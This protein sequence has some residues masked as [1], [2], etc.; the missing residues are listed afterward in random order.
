MVAMANTSELQFATRAERLFAALNWSQ[1]EGREV[2]SPSHPSQDE[3]V[4]Q[5]WESWHDFQCVV[6][7]GEPGSGK[8][9]E[10]RR[11]V[12]ELQQ[13]GEP[14]FM[15]CWQDWCDGDDIFDTI[16]NRCGFFSAIESSQPVWWFV[17][18][19]DEGRIKTEAAFDFLRKGLRRLHRDGRLHLVKLRLSCRSRDWRLSEARQLSVFFDAGNQDGKSTESVATL[20]LLPLHEPSIRLL[21]T[22][23]LRE[24]R[25]V[26]RF[27]ESL[28]QR[29]VSALAGH[30]L[31]LAMMLSLYLEDNSSLAYDRTALYDRAMER[32]ATEHNRERA[33]RK[34]PQTLPGER[35]AVARQ[36]AVRTILG[37]NDT[38]GVPDSDVKSDRI[39]DASRTGAKRFE[40]LETL[41]TGLF[42]QHAEGG[43]VF[44]H[45][46]FA[47]YLAA[48]YLSERIG[49][50]PLSRII[51]LFPVE[52]G[53]IPGPLRE[54][55]SWLAGL[56]DAFRRWLIDRDPLTAA[57]G[58]TIRYTSEERETLLMSLA[59]RFV[60][61]KW[62]REFDRFG[63]LARSVS[64]E[65]LRRLLQKDRS[66]AVRQMTIKMIEVAEVASLFPDLRNIVLDCEEVP[67]LRADATCVLAKHSA[68][69]LAAA[70]S[71]LLQLP[72]GQDPQDDIAGILAH[73]LYPDYLTTDQLLRSL[74]VPRQP[75]TLGHY[76][77]FWEHLFLQRLP[78][79]KEE[80]R[81]SLDAIL[82]L[83]EDDSDFILL[84]PYAEIAT[85]LLVSVLQR[86]DEDIECLGPW[87]VRLGEWIRH[88]GVPDQPLHSQL[89]SALKGHRG[90]GPSLLR[91][92]LSNWSDEQE[93]LPW[94]HVPFYEVLFDGKDTDCWI[95]LSRQYADRSILGRSLFDEV[96]ALAFRY[97]ITVPIEVVEALAT[98]EPAYEARW[99]SARVSDLDGPL[100]R[101]NREQRARKVENES[102]N[103]DVIS[104]VRS[105]IDLLR[106]GQVHPLMWVLHSVSFECFGFV[107]TTELVEKYGHD[108]ARAVRDGVINNWLNFADSSG[109]W[110][111]SN[112]LPNEGLIGGMGFRE[113]YPSNENLPE[114]NEQ[115]V[116]CLV[117]RVLQNESDI[118]GLLP[119]LWDRYRDALWKRLEQTLL[120]ESQ[121]PDDA[122]PTI[123]WRIASIDTRPADLTARLLDH[124]IEHRLPDHARARRY[125][126]KILLS[127]ESPKANDLIQ[128]TIEAEWCSDSVPAPWAEPSAMATLSAWWLRAPEDAVVFLKKEIFHGQRYRPRAVSFV[129]ALQE[130]LGQRFAFGSRWPETVP[131]SDY[132]ELLP[133]L[134]DC[135]PQEVVMAGARWV[136]P[137]D[138]FLHAR[139]GLVVHLASAP[140]Q[141]SYEWFAQWKRDPRF[142]IH[143]DWFA[144][145]H[146][147]IEQRRAD[148][149]WAPLEPATL[150]AVLA[151]QSALIR[152]D[153]DAAAL[154]N[155][156]IASELVPAFRSDHSL[157]PLLWEGTKSAGDRKPRDEKALQTAIYGQLMPMLAKQPVVGAREP[158]VFDAKKPDARISYFLDSGLR[159]DVPIE[160]K[161]AWH[162]D[163]WDATE[164]QVL[165]KYMQDPRVRHAIYIVGWAG[166]QRVKIGPN[167]QEPISPIEFKNQLQDVTNARLDGT[168]KS[169]TV[170]VVD[171]NVLD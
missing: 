73:Y 24:E 11:R 10:F 109:L 63:D 20:Q 92:R 138:E 43:F 85:S 67:G 167:G 23:K 146:A 82:R 113:L 49:H 108:V 71:S 139:D 44:A 47:E 39:V 123:W 59:D 41:D 127:M 51:A 56:S 104:Q 19:L 128:S 93:F 26:D 70:C 148:E 29:H 135:P 3:F 170:H 152:Y 33:D 153:E 18:A 34:P 89:I 165:T 143:R 159:I 75:S 163:V 142:G 101:S 88:H 95:E 57:Q 48:G 72:P 129:S 124:L 69:G 134:Y 90:L 1:L 5:P 45:K 8:T 130:F 112:N 157:V 80:H 53:V 119:V 27:M 62:Q 38:I 7:L 60:D 132:A 114:F 91:W 87:L 21:A 15:S 37:G 145:L 115:Q 52:H 168:G 12:Q 121:L 14:A 78:A 4:P 64:D 151:G 110:P 117:W 32:L 141:V 111:R 162:S 28:E 42:A 65:V 140:A 99:D 77:W 6:L 97:P 50:L 25:A 160:V 102:R 94:W 40:L 66:M 126:L 96:I 61:R 58:D 125:A 54:T 76:R 122:Y 107:P 118:P 31:T 120:A 68:E 149:S 166:I 137:V 46:S 13:A 150:E 131:W 17:D 100:A 156:M 84:Q 136:T 116:Q 86:E 79:T 2:G 169:I 74:R 105:N 133:L 161:W 55:A 30:P 103:A 164:G 171:A 81:V 158:E 36:L 35:I 144:S 155:E 147:E 98:L 16:D 106:S 83:L 9:C 154:L 22:E